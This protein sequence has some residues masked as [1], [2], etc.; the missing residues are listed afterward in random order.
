[1]KK[2]K[3]LNNLVILALFLSILNIILTF[4]LL[5]KQGLFG[6]KPI[7]NQVAGEAANKL[8]RVNVSA[9]DDPVRGD[10]KASVTIIEFGDYQCPYCEI[11][12]SQ[13]LPQI[14]KR[15]IQTGKVKFIY[16]DFPLSF[17]QY[18]GKAA[19]A[20][21]CA[22]EQGKFWDFHDKLYK[23]QNSL[24]LASLKIYA[25]QLGVDTTK[26]NACLDSGKMRA[27]VQKDV[28][29]GGGYGVSGTPA[30]FINGVNVQGAKPFSEF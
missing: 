18:A 26:F 24:D 30:F 5:E 19:E 6:Q 10:K 2:I 4:D 3:L 29:D 14:E 15:Y 27:E 1:M 17:H 28:S 7:K 21:E 25:Q 11:F 9:D 8:P 16:R 13:V 12:F 22:D 23:N 20:T